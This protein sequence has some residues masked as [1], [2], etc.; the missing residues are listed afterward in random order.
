[1]TKTSERGRNI[2]TLPPP[3]SIRKEPHIYNVK[4]IRNYLN[5]DLLIAH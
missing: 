2:P 5:P 1:M 3:P 4:Q